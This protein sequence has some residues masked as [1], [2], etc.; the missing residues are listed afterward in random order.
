MFF[1]KYE[2][3]TVGEGLAEIYK[4]GSVLIE[5]AN[6]GRLLMLDKSGNKVWQYIN[7]SE[8]NNKLYRLNWSR[9]VNLDIRTF[10]ESL[11]KNNECKF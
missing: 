10:K 1:K 9:L 6:S 4:N 11:K 8:E 2:I 7:R 3:R 5:E